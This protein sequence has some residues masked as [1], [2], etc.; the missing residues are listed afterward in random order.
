MAYR[1]IPDK[2]YKARQ[3][4]VLRRALPTDVRTVVGRAELKEPGATLQEARARVPAFIARTDQEIAIARGHLQLGADEHIDRIPHTFNL[5]DPDEVDALLEG[6]CV[7]SDLSDAQRERMVAVVTGQLIPE[8]LYTAKDLIGIATRFKQ[9]AKR[10]H[11]SWSKQLDL[12][13]KF[14]SANSPLPCTKQQVASYRMHLLSRIS[15]ATAKTTLN[16]LSGLWSIWKKQSLVLSTF[17][18]FS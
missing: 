5:Q 6:A 12:F 7:D 8:P 11:E 17:Q 2:F 9:P 10:S 18:R 14:C 16:Y 15:P 13:L 1:R 4:Y 3:G